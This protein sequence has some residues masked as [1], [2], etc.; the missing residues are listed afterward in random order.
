[1]KFFD[2]ILPN[3]SF[4]MQLIII[5]GIGL[6]SLSIVSTMVI[7]NIS[8]RSIEKRLIDEGNSLTSTLASQ[9]TLALLYES[10]DA[11]LDNIKTI[12]SFPDVKAAEIL[13]VSLISLASSGNILRPVTDEYRDHTNLILIHEDNLY[14]EFLSP[15][16]SGSPK[17]TDNPFD[18]TTEGKAL[19][20]YVR[21]VM[22]KKTLNKMTN[23]ILK[24]NLIVSISM[25]AIL[26]LIL[27]AVTG[28]IIT[29]INR[30]A[31]VMRKAQQGEKDIRAEL[32]GT[33]DVIEMESAF[34]AMM[35]VL[36][37]R[38]NSLKIARDQ[39]L[40]SAKAKGEFAANVSHELRT[41]INGILGMLELLNDMGLTRKQAEYIETAENS[42]E[43]LLKLIDEILDFSKNESGQSSLQVKTFS[44]PK[45]LEDVVSLLSPQAQQK[46][47]DIAYINSVDAPTNLIGDGE[48]IK[49]VLLNLSG[50]AI[51][52]TK[53]GDI[54]IDVSVKEIEQD[55]ILLRFSVKDTGIGISNDA[56]SRIFEAFSQADASTTRS[57]G[58]TGL[59]LS[60]SRQLILL[61]GGEIGVNSETGVGS[62]F[63]FELPLLRAHQTAHQ[64]Q[65]NEPI[66]F[67]RRV[68]IIDDSALNL[69]LIESL[70]HQEPCD[71]KLCQN[72]LDGLDLF[73]Q[74]AESN[75]PFDLVLVDEQ[76]KNSKGIEIIRKMALSD[77]LKLTQ[78]VLM[79]HRLNSSPTQQSGLVVSYYLRKPI[80]RSDFYSCL[81]R[82]MRVT[83][84]L[85]EIPVI[86][87]INTQNNDTYEPHI[88]VVEDN[89][90]NQKVALGMLERMGFLADLAQNGKECLDAVMKK[91][92]DLIL[93]DCHM[94][95]MDGYEASAKIR[96]LKTGSNHLPIV[97]MTANIQQGE[98]EKCI[99]AGMD[100]YLPK[101][102]KM[103]I[104]RETLEKH[105]NIVSNASLTEH[106]HKTHIDTE[107]INRN[108]LVE[109]HTQIGDVLYT[110][111]QAYLEDLPI[112]LNALK[113]SIEDNN[114]AS[115][116]DV[117]HTI[118]G[119][120]ANYGAE[121]LVGICQRLENIG[122]SGIIEGA[123]QLMAELT[124][125][126]ELVRHV[127]ANE[128]QLSISDR[129]ATNTENITQDPSNQPTI[130]IV[131]DDRGSRISMAEV[132]RNEGY[133]VVEASDGREAIVCCKRTPPNVVLMDAIM[134]KIDGFT[135][136]SMIKNMPETRETPVLII[137]S[138]NDE[139]SI[140]RAFSSGATDYI[141]KPVNFSV[142]RQRIAL[143][144]QTNHAEQR[145]KR[146]AYKD[147][148]TGLP[149]RAMFNER[150]NEML[151]ATRNKK[152]QLAL[153]FLDL[154]RF[155]LVNDTMGHE[156]GD[157]LL[158][159]FGERMQNC[160]RKGDLVARFGGDEFTII[161]DNIESAQTVTGVVNKIHEQLSKPFVFMGKK[162]YVNTSIGISV[163][164]ED[165]QEIGT[166]LKKAD[167]AMYRAKENGQ[168]YQFYEDHM[169][170][171][172]S[173]R[174]D[175]ENDLRGAIERDEMMVFYQPQIDLKTGRL[176][177]KEA[178]IRW[179]HSTRGL[180]NPID[181]IGLAEETGQIW[182]IGKW[183]LQQSCLQQK[184]WLDEGHNSTP[185]S[186]NL[187][188]KQLTHPDLLKTLTEV[189]V[190]TGLEPRYLEL[191]ITESTIMENPE[192]V[193]ITLESLKSM[194]VMLSIDDF[195]T[196]YSS[197][198]YL[199]RFPI[200][201]I[202]IDRMFV[203]DLSANNVDADIVK[204]I[205]ALAHIMDVRVVAEGVENQTQIDILKRHRCDIIQGYFIGK[206]TDSDSFEQAFSGDKVLIGEQGEL[207]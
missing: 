91:H 29:P 159:Y 181:F 45:I 81:N 55:R 154:N 189:L 157:L 117:A 173:K 149:N 115:F 190:E 113:E 50:N 176:H 103:N 98:A 59:G 148:L 21:L 58:G 39:A 183:V 132:L 49:Q 203:S 153:M 18:D 67:N 195:G 31:A 125:E 75:E 83:Q 46:Q 207:D 60:I 111:I 52:F 175:L 133:K 114:T 51:K 156:A 118:K 82:L 77:K 102:L 105:L 19:I 139:N 61:M 197:L 106:L 136:C 95:E 194:G 66:G 145:V 120:S 126:S 191:E 119:S 186:V 172:V 143:L 185:V 104:L 199:K 174:L 23:N 38:E 33:V 48:K 193:I 6:L 64:K 69:R 70:L 16:Y 36:E 166:L 4:R 121:R 205:I 142:L 13:D 9:S 71:Y 116:A 42:G 27:L 62:E 96:A 110:M 163:F 78:F 92:Y 147:I 101:P 85:T 93:M 141:S 196:G 108:S 127:L 11:A 73:Q 112:Y 204:T 57:Y 131:D 74:A 47:L 87:P 56:Q 15:V 202:K 40:E 165:G 180:I 2:R 10:E 80:Q 146:L 65:K 192:S 84:D 206:P 129:P 53:S 162:I 94:P 26:L 8:S 200:D 167:M 90:A 137:T 201:I 24:Y 138:L 43:S 3:T 170:F 151:T 158:K 28:R 68:L 123:D 41:P 20:G 178:L 88:L 37:K 128:Y 97:A 187:S 5:F 34:N 144:V 30:L 171:Q 135:A 161:L 169:Q 99:S 25:A 89:R 168:K 182:E 140:G 32:I 179:N 7:S 164:P 22:S 72:S 124:E 109:L 1:M 152:K 160:M 86:Q 130:L 35:D 107:I 12:L 14:W 155:K 100:D 134:P 122:R 184:K 188:G 76:L 63:W 44:L 17:I 79:T 54:G 150:F 198:S 177:G